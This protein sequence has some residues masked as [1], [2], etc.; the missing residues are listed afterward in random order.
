[1]KTTLGQYCINVS[2]LDRAVA[3]YEGAIG[4]EITNRIE[5]EDFREVILGTPDGARI[6]LAY[7]FGED[8][9]IEHGNSFWKHYVYTDDCRTLYERALASGGESVLEP[10]TLERWK[11]TVAM[12]KDP[13]GYQLEIIQQD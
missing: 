5:E 6:Q 13:D 7:H 11:C 8:G 1:M 12:V 2:N 4:L 9:P 10:Q 3:F